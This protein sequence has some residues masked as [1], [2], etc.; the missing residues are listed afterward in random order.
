MKKAAL[1][2]RVSTS[3]QVDKDSLPFQRQ[4]LSNYS[5]YVLG[6]DDYEIFEDAG[7][8]AKNT[9]RPRYQEMMARIKSKEFSHLLVW[10]IDR[11]SRNLKD[12]T[13][14]YDDLKEYGI[15]FISKNEQFDTS[16]A[17]GEAMLK[18]I[19][20]FAELERKLTA[21]RVT[22]I[23]LSRAEKGLWN[24]ATVPLGYVWSDEVKF[25]VVDQ[26]EAQV[27][28][29]IYD[30]Y[31]KL[32]STTK[33]AYQLNDEGV[34]SKRGGKFTA[35]TVN[36]VIRN[37]F[38]I[39]TY[40]YNAKVGGTRRWKDKKEWIVVED[41]HP[42]IIS[43]DQ[44]YRATK[45]LS[46]NYNGD[47]ANQR[48]NS[49]VH[50][51]AK[52]L[53]CSKC[54]SS[55]IAGLDNPRKDGY[56]PARYTCYTNRH[57][58]NV[59]NC[60][61]F[62][63]DI[64]LLPFILNYLSNFINL[65]NKITSRHSLRDI[66]RILLRGNAFVDVE[67]IDRAGLE[68]T[69]TAFVG[70]R[71]NGSVFELTEQEEAA[72]NFELEKLKKEKQKF[73][74]ALSRLEDLFLFSDEAMAK[75]DFLFKKRDIIANIERINGELSSLHE[76]LYASGAPSDINFLNKASNFLILNELSGKRHIDY[77]ELL[78]IVDKTLLR[79][80]VESAIEKI[81]IKDKRIDSI[82]FSN[83][84]VHKFV[85]KPVEERKHRTGERMLYLSFE[86]MLM[87][88]LSEHGSVNRVEVEKLT[89]MTRTSALSLINEFMD[90]GILEKRGNSTA[91]RYFLIKKDHLS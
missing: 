50:T 89:G 42:A 49:H 2:V 15:T 23:M 76:R 17:M 30:L 44:Y 43:Q 61:C 11:I 53:Y 57:V 12:F 40:R 90:R 34:K 46:D 31:E 62:V 55:L 4:E 67:G 39:G 47:G 59:N 35:K 22:S 60:N 27:V 48:V 68:S 24:G 54:G 25:P 45:M 37:P 16:T 13:Q 26:D 29:Y 85:Y 32:K 86:P 56:R 58:R 18:I 81:V 73:E 66:E 38:Y 6:I 84:I 75:K 77:R 69:Y 80:F 70:G 8:S 72:P 65:Q 19:L 21:E 52:M 20:V 1:Y 88:H 91:T 63:S 79:E 71:I 9:D 51:F 64:Q 87:D 28:Q 82:T 41:N 36:D 83:G 74:K 7:Y 3:H 10:K 14:M 5:K 33:V 78:D